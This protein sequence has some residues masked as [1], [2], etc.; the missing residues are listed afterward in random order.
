MKLRSI[1]WTYILFSV[2]Q[3]GGKT[4]KPAPPKEFYAAQDLAEKSVEDTYNSLSLQERVN[5]LSI[6]VRKADEFPVTADTL[7]TLNGVFFDANAVQIG[8]VDVDHFAD[9]RIQMT[10]SSPSD[11]HLINR[12]VIGQTGNEELAYY[13]EAMEMEHLRKTGANVVLG[14][15]FQT[16]MPN[17]QN[18]DLAYFESPLP[19]EKYWKKTLQAAAANGI[20][21]GLNDVFFSN[22]EVDTLQMADFIAK[23]MSGSRFYARKGDGIIQLNSDISS[24]KARFKRFEDKSRQAFLRE[25]FNFDGV[26]VS[27]DYSSLNETEQIA[28]AMASLKAGSDLV[29]VA[30]NVHKTLNLSLE[31]YFS[32]HPDELKKHG[33]K[34]LQLK[35]DLH[36]IRKKSTPFSSFQKPF[37][38]QAKTAALTLIKSENKAIPISNLSDTISFFTSNED[39]V[40]IQEEIMHYAPAR[41][42]D[43]LS[44]K[45]TKTTILDGFGKGIDEALRLATNYPGATKYILLT[46]SKTFRSKRTANF[47][48]FSG[49]ILSSEN[50]PLDRSLAVQAL[51]GAHAFAG[52]LPF[53]HSPR[54]PQGAGMSIRS[55]D[56]LKYTS[57]EYLGISSDYLSEIDEIAEE[58]IR[59]KAFPGCQV[60]FAA[61]GH[62]VYN[63]N[64][65]HL[66]YTKN[67]EVTAN[68]LYDIAS[69]TKIAASTASLMVLQGED[70]LS[71]EDSLYQL[72]P[73]V[74]QDYPMKN[75]WMKD[76]MAHQAGLPA[77]IPF[78][79][80]TLEHGEPSSVYYKE[81]RQGIF[82]APV[83]ANLWM[84]RDYQDSMYTRILTSQLGGRSYK[85][86]D[87]GYYFV[88][89]IIE[90]KSGKSL[91][92][93][94]RDAIYTPLGLQTM[95]FNPYLRFPLERIAPTENDKTFRKQVV[96]GYVHDPGAAMM[97]GVCGHA[98]V[99]STANDLA[100]FM[101]MLLNKGFY[102]GKQILD[103]A[104]VELYTGVQFPG[105]SRR[106]AGFD[107]PNLN[108]SAATACTEANPDSFGHSGFTGTLV[109]ADPTDKINYVFLSNRVYPNAENWKITK[110]NIRT[111]IQ[112]KI[113]Q[114]VRTARN[115]NFLASK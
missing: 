29:C 20:K 84:R 62:V 33:L 22:R 70:K 113:Y 97:G 51:F 6:I 4:G 99:F 25:E 107:K 19:S 11:F 44:A 58:S 75:I 12:L 65:G 35:Y 57:P 2:L 48:V 91:E 23:G 1:I 104:I 30:E 26:I 36:Q 41:V 10:T 54:Y 103:P 111:R 81:T 27:E 73:N 5:L 14:Q 82:T 112:K 28:N 37:F 89:K 50:T 102:G 69:I 8:S 78:Y 94:T 109:W 72:I 24:F 68:T 13:A 42:F 114:S 32:K 31:S 93:F 108:G 95:M 34:V 43:H 15:K 39:A 59:A 87:L 63:K 86:S 38:Y 16:Y 92:Q 3:L 56:R 66:D 71:L 64:F 83:A 17:W 105:R 85:Y 40:L 77:W 106:G 76:M 79:T 60:L 90:A 115:F 47:S 80:K 18:E 88:K 7:Q 49:I 110:M 52:E 101:Q 53:Y 61:D 67:E 55:L 21:L 98:G 74:V 96:R 45:T 9:E 100:I 46:D